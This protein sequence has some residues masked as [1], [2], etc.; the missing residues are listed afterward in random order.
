M[1]FNLRSYSPTNFETRDFCFNWATCIDTTHKEICCSVVP[2][3]ANIWYS[4]GTTSPNTQINYSH[5]LTYS[6]PHSLTG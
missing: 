4:S 5:I 3:F 6:E 1:N 2:L